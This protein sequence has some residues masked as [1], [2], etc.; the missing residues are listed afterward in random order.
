MII[1]KTEEF[2]AMKNELEALR[3]KVEEYDAIMRDIVKILDEC[4][5]E[6]D[7]GWNPIIPSIQVG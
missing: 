7:I 2:V 4:K 3:K 6:E 1:V 5:D